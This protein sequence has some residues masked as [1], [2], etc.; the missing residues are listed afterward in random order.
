MLFTLYL[1]T[2]I[3]FILIMK[4]TLMQN[5]WCLFTNNCINFL[6]NNKYTIINTFILLIASEILLASQ[7][8]FNFLNTFILFITVYLDFQMEIVL[9]SVCCI[10]L[11]FGWGFV[12]KYFWNQDSLT[13][14]NRTF[15][16]WCF[17]KYLNEELGM[18]FAWDENEEFF[19]HEM[20]ESLD[21]DLL[22]YIISSENLYI[23][24]KNINFFFAFDAY[25]TILRYWTLVCAFA[26]TA[27]IPSKYMQKKFTWDTGLLII[28]LTTFIILITTTNNLFMFYIL[29]EGINLALIALFAW[30]RYNI[31]ALEAALKYF[32]LNGLINGLLLFSLI[33]FY[34]QTNS[35]NLIDLK[36]YITNTSG[37]NW[38]VFLFIVAFFFKL[39]AWP[40]HVWTPDIYEGA[41]SWVIF[42]MAVVLKSVLFAL[43]L[44]FLCYI[45]FPILVN[46]KTL[47]YIS[48]LG[49]IIIGTFGALWQKSLKRFLAYSTI[50]NTGLC[51]ITLSTSN[52]LHF[53]NISL[54]YFHLFFYFIT[55]FFLFALYFQF[56]QYGEKRLYFFSDYFSL[57]FYNSIELKLLIFLFLNVII[58]MAALPP[59]ITFYTKFLLFYCLMQEKYYFTVT[60]LLLLNCIMSYYYLRLIKIFYFEDP[61]FEIYKAITFNFAGSDYNPAID[62]KQIALNKN[63]LFWVTIFAIFHWKLT[64]FFQM[65]IELFISF[66]TYSFN[67]L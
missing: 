45:F 26:V 57:G 38:A 30:R 43:F 33:L 40:F 1:A 19:I 50:V 5:K 17:V 52:T 20:I 21:I 56:I 34:Y 15:I 35:L 48:G 18:Y 11:I 58:L 63:T 4:N 62:K 6:K 23:A 47:F 61:R 7:W 25:T 64:L 46:L 42:Y 37:Y 36:Y 66:S 22:P 49:S 55:T 65:F 53:L 27:C 41:P 3:S 14:L 16:V 28:L 44:K 31:W 12:E 32:V 54:I 67:I 9:F 39:S 8:S 60:L 51:L 13:I 24:E 29:L 2:N 59:A 10:I